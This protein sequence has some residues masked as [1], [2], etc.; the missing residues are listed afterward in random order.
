MSR[1]TRELLFC[2]PLLQKKF[3]CFEI[4]CRKWPNEPQLG[5]LQS[6]K[7]ISGQKQPNWV[8]FDWLYGVK[9]A[10][11]VAF[12]FW[13]FSAILA[14]LRSFYSYFWLYIQLFLSVNVKF[15][16]RGI[17]TMHFDPIR[18]LQSQFWWYL[19]PPSSVIRADITLVRDIGSLIFDCF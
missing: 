13:L 1:A 16:W 17:Q 3:R 5:L 4:F 2:P 6:K 19:W 7:L 14:I 15:I 18:G 11:K 10:P 9:Y 12:W 8:S